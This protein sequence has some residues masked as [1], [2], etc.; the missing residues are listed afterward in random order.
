VI[1]GA[2]G[3]WF[4]SRIMGGPDLH[5]VAM[6][7]LVLPGLAAVWL[8]RRHGEARVRRR[9]SA[10]RVFPG[11]TVRVAL[12]LHD[13][14]PG[15]IKLLEDR[16]PA[17]FGRNTRAVVVGSGV[18]RQMS[19]EL[20]CRARG[21]Y[22]IGP[23]RISRT[24]PFDLIR[25]GTDVPG[26]TELVVYPEVED[27]RAVRTAAVGTGSGESVSRRLFRT[28]DEFY[29]IRGY[30]LGDD[31]R[32]IHWASTARMRRLMIRHDEAA[33]RSSAVILIDS[34]SASVGGS[35]SVFE[36]AV[37]AA[38]SVGVHLARSGFTLQLATPDGVPRVVSRADL[39][40]ALALATPS[41]TGSLI[42]ALR[43]V[44]D[45]ARNGADVI[46]VTHLPLPPEVNAMSRIHGGTRIA[47]LLPPEDPAA[48]APGRQAELQ[49]WMQ[50]VRVSLETAGWDVIFLAPTGHLRDVWQLRG[51]SIRA[52]VRS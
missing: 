11:T 38:A 29:T 51:T 28:G 19:Y 13:R 41:R 43:E 23:L 34:R 9:L 7:L 30:Q 44:A 3:L 32:R 33:R 20:L 21:R 40:E 27:L 39:L 26:T 10:T 37:S 5:V 25:R 52:G 4:A 18:N 8:L 45:R 15:G 49:A 24:D 2:L 14:S 48:L 16:L 46:L 36:R 50:S 1:A 17:S 31:L 42:P 12:D 22:Q 6:G 47:I 35:K